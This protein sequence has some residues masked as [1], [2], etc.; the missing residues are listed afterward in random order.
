M[1]SLAEL[2]IDQGIAV[3]GSV[4]Q[5]GRIQ[6]IGGANYKIEGFFDV[7]RAKGFSGKQGVIIPHT[8]IKNLMLRSDVVDAIKKGNFHIYPIE[9]VDEGIRILTGVTAGKLK[10]DGT[11]PRNSVN[12]KIMA[13]LGK[14]D[15]RFK[16]RRTARK[17]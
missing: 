15:A 14:M 13:R 4:N 7:C 16:S 9:T 1:S 5:H 17:K 3:T 10:K 2:P 12:G 6:P 8:N 11:Y